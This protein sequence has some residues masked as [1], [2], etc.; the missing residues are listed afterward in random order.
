MTFNELPLVGKMVSGNGWSSSAGKIRARSQTAT[1]EGTIMDRSRE[2]NDFPVTVT[3]CNTHVPEQ[4]FVAYGLFL[5]Q[6]IFRTGRTGFVAQETGRRKQQVH[7]QSGIRARA[8]GA[9]PRVCCP[10]LRPESAPNPILLLR[11]RTNPIP[12]QSHFPDPILA[13]F[14]LLG[15]VPGLGGVPVFSAVERPVPK[16]CMT[17]CASMCICGSPGA[18]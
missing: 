16:N 13:L 12:D 11:K 7:L 9:S 15:K 10:I 17:T 1:R 4:W 5:D 8:A 14:L 6:V 3:V 2:L 18:R